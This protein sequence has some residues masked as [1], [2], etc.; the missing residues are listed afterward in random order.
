[1]RIKFDEDLAKM[2]AEL[3]RMGNLC[4]TAIVKVFRGLE[5]SDERLLDEVVDTDREIDQKEREIENM[6]FR[7]MLKQHP[8]AHDMLQVS[9]V[10]KLITDMERIGD[11][12]AD[13]ADIAKFVGG[14]TN[15][16]A[17]DFNAMAEILSDMLNDVIRAFADKDLDLAYQVMKEDDTVDQYF[18][19]IREKLVVMI[20]DVNFDPTVCLDLMMIAKY[21]ERIG[22]HAVNIAEWTEYAIR[23]VHM[24]QEW[25]EEYIREHKKD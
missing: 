8:V 7:I 13:I 17:D 3:I 10:L 20:R 6:C 5:E 15:G 2:N 18:E 12:A 4:E 9:S 25:K 14:R 22:D 16:L 24:S 19:Q 21:C 1:M 11:H 23:G